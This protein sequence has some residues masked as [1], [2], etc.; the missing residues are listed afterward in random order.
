MIA[1]PVVTVRRTQKP[2]P[3]PSQV[4]AGQQNDGGGAWWSVLVVGAA[5]ALPRI[6]ASMFSKV[7]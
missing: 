7:S 6:E 5:K 4:L 3:K 2:A 1:V